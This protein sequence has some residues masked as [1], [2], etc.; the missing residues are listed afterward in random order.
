MGRD[1]ERE[2]RK[3]RDD[4]TRVKYS[5]VKVYLQRIQEDGLDEK[6]LGND[7]RELA[8]SLLVAVVISYRTHDRRFKK[9]QKTK[10]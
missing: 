4:R 9:S 2:E 10:K 3:M 7:L 5:A 8:L 6:N 1:R